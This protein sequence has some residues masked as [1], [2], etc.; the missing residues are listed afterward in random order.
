MPL[1]KWGSRRAALA[2]ASLLLSAV[3][4]AGVPDKPDVRSSSVMVIDASDSAVL[5]SRHANVAA[6]I[7]SITKLMTAIVVLEG[8]QP[9]TDTLEI[10][11]DDR[12]N[13][14][15]AASRLAVGTKL[16]RGDLLHIALMSSDNRAAH[17]V[18]RNYPGGVPALV[19]AMNAKAKTL[20]MTTARF[21]DP[22][23]LSE[24]NVASAQDLC[25]LV[26]AAARNPTVRQYSTDHEYSVKAGRRM[27]AFRNTNTLV[28]KADW[29]ILVQKTG[30][31]N[32]AGRCLVMKT[33]IKER[34]VVIVLLDSFGKY[35]RVADARR[36]RKWL[37][38]RN[39]GAATPAVADKV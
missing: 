27:L 20:G 28:A 33:V 8:G 23:G 1:S 38:A 37:E 18:G 30:Y 3:T 12:V 24:L 32:E 36:I 25:L 21:V 14:K 7:A 34:P 31:T 39:F 22:T 5:F 6:P 29:K 15:G 35:T 16:S 19:R 9:L 26:A 17:A 13:G 10:T 2:V 11:Q 4:A